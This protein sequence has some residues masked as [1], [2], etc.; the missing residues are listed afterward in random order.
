MW[1]DILIYATWLGKSDAENG[2]K[3][4]VAIMAKPNAFHS[5]AKIRA[6]SL[7]EILK[8]LSALFFSFVLLK[9]KFIIEFVIIYFMTK[10]NFKITYIFVH[11]N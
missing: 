8:L 2:A 11:L 10:G 6:R 7:I 9:I 3:K 5:G 1:L 4:W